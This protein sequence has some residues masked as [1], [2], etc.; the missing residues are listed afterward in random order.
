MRK[1]L[2]VC[3]VLAVVAGV[4]WWQRDELL[5][6][7]CF[8]QLDAAD[9]KGRQLWINRLIALDS[10]VVPRAMNCLTQP[11]AASCANAEA[12]LIALGEKW[13]TG[14][15][16]ADNLLRE[17]SA[18]W[19]SLSWAGKS[20]ALKVA[21]ALVDDL[22]RASPRASRASGGS[23]PGP[24]GRL[25]EASV[26]LKLGAGDYPLQRAALKLAGSLGNMAADST[27]SAILTPLAELGLKS[28][29]ADIRT[30]AVH[31]YLYPPLNK[32][33]DLLARMAPLLRDGSG[34]V[35][36]AALLVL[37]P[38]QD[39]LAVD[40]LLPLLHDPDAEVCRLCEVVLRSRGLGDQ[41]IMLARLISDENPKVRLEVL[42]FLDDAPDLDPG[43][44]LR[45]LCQ[46]PSPAVRAAAARAAGQARV[47]L[48]DR[49]RELAQNDASPTVRQIASLNLRLCSTHR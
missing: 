9:A 10:A 14:D 24:K 15:D 38:R 49:L 13:G 35:R 33:A 6:W 36:R 42:E 34:Q 30:L 40:D 37:G 3:L 39:L 29:E 31:L 41:H 43:V 32:G 4:G 19:A 11:E 22:E 45:R 8:R 48:S 44:W 21:A 1:F 47:D 46:D 20:S 28:H 17:L 7:Y 16:R 2:V 5:G 25:K 27:E 23:I 12:V 26:L 18:N